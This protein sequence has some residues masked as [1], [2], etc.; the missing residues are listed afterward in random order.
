MPSQQFAPESFSVFYHTFTLHEK[1]SSFRSNLP[2]QILF[3]LAHIAHA[4]LHPQIEASIE[5][6]LCLLL[7]SIDG[8]FSGQDHGANGRMKE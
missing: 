2:A 1:K 4:E 5:V 6:P 8:L 7:M 3:K